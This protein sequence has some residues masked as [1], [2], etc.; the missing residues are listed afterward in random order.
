MVHPFAALRAV[1]HKI[2]H[3]KAEVPIP[4]TPSIV[5]VVRA[6][7]VVMVLEAEAVYRLHPLK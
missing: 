1:A 3:L 7:L 6:A 2:E 4:P 5:K